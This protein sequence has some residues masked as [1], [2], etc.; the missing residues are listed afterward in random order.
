MGLAAVELAAVGSRHLVSGLRYLDGLD[1]FDHTV[2]MV[3]VVV[4]VE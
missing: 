2:T 1:W 3:V 4:V